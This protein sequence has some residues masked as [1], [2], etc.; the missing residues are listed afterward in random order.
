MDSRRA[1]AEA[2]F[3]YIGKCILCIKKRSAG[4]AGADPAGCGLAR[5]EVTAAVRNDIAEAIRRRRRILLAGFFA[6][7]GNGLHFQEKCFIIIAQ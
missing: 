2:P 5:S 6:L 7:S 1:M 3:C 4:I